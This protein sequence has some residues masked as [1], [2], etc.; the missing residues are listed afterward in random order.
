MKTATAK[1]PP[2]QMRKALLAQLHIAPKDLGMAD[3]DAQAVKRRVTGKDS[4]KDMTLKQMIDVQ[5]EFKR[6]GWKPTASKRHGAKPKAGEDKAALVGKIEALLADAG[7]PWE[8][9]TKKTESLKVKEATRPMSLLERITGNADGE[10]TQ[11][12][13]RIEFCTVTDLRKIAAML[14]YD[15]QRRAKQAAKEATQG[16]AM[17]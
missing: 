17:A 12:K 8:Y 11:G 2:A 7:R 15:Q 5:K 13:E 3:A 4:L 1:K 14:V 16:E 10:R 9:L 6:L